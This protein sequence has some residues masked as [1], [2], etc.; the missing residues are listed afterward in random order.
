MGTTYQAIK[1]STNV[2]YDNGTSYH[3]QM[4]G[5]AH[6]MLK[7]HADIQNLNH[8]STQ[9]LL[10]AK[11]SPLRRQQPCDRVKYLHYFGKS[12]TTRLRSPVYV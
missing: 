12:K 7:L 1:S 4:Q 6:S 10:F 3:T 8:R 11:F 9:H 5:V 2:G